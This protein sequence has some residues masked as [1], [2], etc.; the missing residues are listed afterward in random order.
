MFPS[1]P[2]RDPFYRE[3][4]LPPTAEERGVHLAVQATALVGLLGASLGVAFGP[5]P[6]VL[7]WNTAFRLSLLPVDSGPRA[8]PRE[9]VEH[10]SEWFIVASV[11]PAV[12]WLGAIGFAIYLATRPAERKLG[13]W[14][15]GAGLAILLFGL[16]R[17]VIFL[18]QHR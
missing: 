15:L 7:A 17:M 10:L 14:G 12:A 5:W 4:D 8:M 11:F 2:R 1:S 9:R 6:T 3:P 18:T 16:I 13:L